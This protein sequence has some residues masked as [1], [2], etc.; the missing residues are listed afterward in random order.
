MRLYGEGQI[1]RTIAAEGIGKDDFI[2]PRGCLAMI[3]LSL[4]DSLRLR[5]Y[6][7]RSYGD[8]QGEAIEETLT[9]VAV[10]YDF[11]ACVYT[12]LEPYLRSTICL[13]EGDGCHRADPQAV[14]AQAH[15]YHRA[16]SC[17][18]IG[19]RPS[20]D[21]LIRDVI[22]YTAIVRVVAPDFVAKEI[23]ILRFIG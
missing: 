16:I 22:V 8:K 15:P 17:T 18:D 6:A 5:A 13:A 20:L 21:K 7:P 2:A 23:I 3:A 10:G 12:R 14:I 4:A 9:A 1:Q 11:I 19:T